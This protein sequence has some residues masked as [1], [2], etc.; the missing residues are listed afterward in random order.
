MTA[1]VV[2]PRIYPGQ[3]VGKWHVIAA[4]ARRPP[5]YRFTWRC[6]CDCGT[7]KEVLAQDLLSGRAT[8][9]G[10]DTR[11]KRIATRLARAAALDALR[12]NH[13]EARR[14]LAI[15]RDALAATQPHTAA[16]FSKFLERQT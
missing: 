1:A 10:C 3:Q 15:A 11:A 6:R 14:L 16:M 12:R 4:G 13:D 5:H 8:S 7:G 2:K 9:C